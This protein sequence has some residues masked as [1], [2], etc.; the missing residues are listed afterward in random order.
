[1]KESFLK[2]STKFIKKYNSNYT[3][4]DIEK[5][6]Y[7]LEGLYLTIT[8]IV[9]IIILSLILGITKELLL[10]LLFFNLIR[11]PAFGVHADKS[12]TCLITSVLL[13]LGFTY[14]F[15]N[16]NIALNIKVLI[17]II[18]FIHYP[19]FAP[20][21]T[22]KRPLTNKR[23]RKYRKIAACI[24][25]LIYCVIVLLFNNII[26]TSILIALL[27][28]AIMINPIT[29]KIYGMPYNNYKETV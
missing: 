27:L 3:D 18:C 6:K 11:F 12:I 7:G 2:S 20:A 17:C 19:L 5:I 24:M 15:F 9:I 4:E 29:Y 26:S 16:I 25:A 10:V 13:I 14:L 8:K 22:I 21:D 1:M 23:K 28:E